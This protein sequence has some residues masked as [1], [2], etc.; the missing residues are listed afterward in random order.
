MKDKQKLKDLIY[1]LL[2]IGVLFICVKMVLLHKSCSANNIQDTISPYPY[3]WDLYED[4]CIALN[5]NSI[6]YIDT[7]N[8]AIYYD[9]YDQF[10]MYHEYEINPNNINNDGNLLVHIS[11]DNLVELMNRILQYM[12]FNNDYD[13]SHK[14][15]SM[16]G[17]KEIN[18]SYHVVYLGKL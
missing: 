17:I 18:N 3:E 12:S 15:E 14:I 5:F 6:Y 7:T 2:L 9:D 10:D 16:F 13:T 8:M 1:I 11:K 4:G